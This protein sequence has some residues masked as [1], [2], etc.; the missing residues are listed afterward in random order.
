[1]ASALEGMTEVLR[2]VP[3]AASMELRTRKIRK[4]D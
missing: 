3:E 2:N 1:M 4:N